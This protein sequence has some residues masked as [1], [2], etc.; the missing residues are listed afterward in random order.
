MKKT[1]LFLIIV[2][3]MTPILIVGYYAISFNYNL[4]KLIN[5]NP[6]LTSTIYD[7]NDNKIANIFKKQDRF[8]VPFARIPARMIEA[9]VATEDTTFFEN[10]GINIDA[11]FRAL[12]KDI[13]ARRIVEGAST[14]TQQLIK[15]VLLTP[16]KTISRKIHGIIYALLLETKLTKDQILERYLNQVYLGHGYY[17]IKTAAQGY[18]HKNLDE[19]SLKEFAIL[20]GLPQAPS[21]FAP[22]KNYQISLARANHVIQR[23]YSLGWISKPMYIK[24]L[25][26]EPKVYNTSLTQNRAPYVV[27]EVLRRLKGQIPD[28]QTGG[29]KIYTTI[30]LKLQQNGRQALLLGY[31][32]TL[33]RL[34]RKLD[35]NDTNTSQLNGALISLNPK[36]GHILALVGGINYKQSPFNR[37]TMAKRQPGSA[38]KPFIYQTAIDLGYSGASL[39]PDVARS[40][41]YDKKGK[42]IKWQP[43]NYERNYKGLITLRDALINSKNLATINLVMQIGL[44]TMIEHLKSFGIKNIP[45][46][47]TLALGSITL[48]PLQLAQYY[49]SF[50]NHGI[51][52]TPILITKITKNGEI[53]Y[54]NQAKK[55]YIT[56]S[57]QTFIMT[58]ILEDVIRYGTGGYAYT[59]GI[60]LAGKTGTTNND[61]DGWFAGYS[62]TIE[63]VVWF[64]NNN[65]TPMYK[66]ET[67]GR[68]SAPAFHYFY[69]KLIKDYPQIQRRFIQ[70]SGIIKVKVRGK[71]EYFSNI[72]KPPKSQSD[73]KQE[74][75]LL[76]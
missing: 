35:S 67:G 53:I 50:A 63:T 42:E 57:Q 19:L 31:H 52:T 47:L 48:T 56:S 38:F 46:N 75:K 14:L 10:P 5:Y 2:F 62:P 23:M 11:M 20:A 64:G 4:K 37:A 55:R 29:Y 28:I 51:Q 7:T 33:R 26:A 27:D 40:Y 60:Q 9:I 13:K 49:T 71:M 66:G 59:K 17:G 3:I 73:I 72:S 39:L 8:Y 22:T 76:F 44:H 54:Q 61:V 24:A 41:S 21:F 36:N 68:V 12:I 30:N 74:D 15:N 65:N 69:Q 18:F 58:T 32:R 34:Q 6:S 43:E 16:K 45:N 70:P 1:I 25:S